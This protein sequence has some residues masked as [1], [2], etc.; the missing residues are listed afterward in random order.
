MDDGSIGKTDMHGEYSVLGSS[1]NNGSNYFEADL[2][3][4]RRFS[5]EE[6]KKGSNTFQSGSLHH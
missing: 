3:G 1:K 4:D 5:V 2:N 6:E